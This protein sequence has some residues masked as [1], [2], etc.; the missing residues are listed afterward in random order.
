MQMA[1]I[2]WRLVSLLSCFLNIQ[3][4]KHPCTTTTTPAPVDLDP[5]ATTVTS[6]TTTSTSTTTTTI[7]DPDSNET[8]TEAPVADE[9]IVQTTTSTTTTM[10]PRWNLNESVVGKESYKCG[11]NL[12]P[13]LP[14][15]PECECA[16]GYE[17]LVRMD[18]QALRAHG[19]DPDAYNV[20]IRCAWGFEG[21]SGCLP[22]LPGRYKESPGNHICAGCDDGLYAGCS[23]LKCEQ[24]PKGMTAPVGA[25]GCSPCQKGRYGKPKSS[26][27]GE[28]CAACPKDTTSPAGSS[29]LE[30]CGCFPGFYGNPTDP[31]MP[32][33]LREC[34]PCPAGAVC[35]GG[36]W[37][38]FKPVAKLGYYDLSEA[39]SQ[40]IYIKKRYLGLEPADPYFVFGECRVPAAC[41]Q[42]FG[43][44]CAPGHNGT[45]CNMCQEG[46]FRPAQGEL[47]K[48]CPS[49]FWNIVF[50]G[51]ASILVGGSIFFLVFVILHTKGDAAK[52][53]HAIIFKI[54]FSYVVLT[55]SALTIT[56]MEMPSILM[57]HGGWVIT[58]MKEFQVQEILT[59]NLLSV[60][61]MYSQLPF[62][63]M[64]YAKTLMQKRLVVNL[65]ALPGLIVM[66]FVTEIVLCILQRILRKLKKCW[67]TCRGKGY[68]YVKP[69][70]RCGSLYKWSKPYLLVLFFFVHPML[71]NECLRG[72]FCVELHPDYPQSTFF[73]YDMDVPC[74]GSTIHVRF[75]SLAGLFFWSIFLPIRLY[76]L[77]KKNKDKLQDEDFKKHWGF[78]YNGY[79]PR[80]AYW[81]SV[82]FLRKLLIVASFV[83]PEL[84]ELERM[85]FLLMVGI[86][87]LW[88]HVY[89][90][91]Y[92]NRSYFLLDRLET[93]MLWA[94]VITLT[95]GLCLNPGIVGDS[96]K[97]N[98]EYQII[99]GI[100]MLVHLR[101]VQLLAYFVIRE[102]LGKMFCP[103]AVQSRKIKFDIHTREFD[104]SRLRSHERKFF[105]AIL[106]DSINIHLQQLNFFAFHY[107]ETAVKEGM[108]PLLTKKARKRRDKERRAE[109]LRQAREK[110][111]EEAA[112]QQNKQAA[113]QMLQPKKKQKCVALKK[114]CS[115][116][117][118]MI[119][120]ICRVPK[121]PCKGRKKKKKKAE[122][123]PM[124]VNPDDIVPDEPVFCDW[125]TDGID[126]ERLQLEMLKQVKAPVQMFHDETQKAEEEPKNPFLPNISTHQGTGLSEHTTHPEYRTSHAAQREKRA[127]QKDE[128]GEK[129]KE[130]SRKKKASKKN[131]FDDLFG[132]EEVVMEFNTDLP[133]VQDDE[134][135]E[136]GDDQVLMMWEAPDW[137]EKKEE[138][139]ELNVGQPRKRAET[140]H[141]RVKAAVERF[142]SRFMGAVPDAPDDMEGPE[143]VKAFAD[144]DEEPDAFWTAA[145]PGRFPEKEVEDK[146]KKKKK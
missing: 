77:L 132:A 64:G 89:F 109:A 66:I 130:T 38:E 105:V 131:Q 58:Y 96:N 98:L 117:K 137:L 39:L 50:I 125:W 44:P 29:E 127:V 91:P 142:H 120:L 33:S 134:D 126:V 20:K 15:R 35:P 32:E 7:F 90:E 107:I 18:F 141:D 135:E 56:Q 75:A 128:Q 51:G 42:T 9:C 79:E 111:L 67:G 37:P 113:E 27:Q 34:N 13:G 108:T 103:L 122:E 82:I 57:T 76:R 22:C 88:C 24:C 133:E 2:L 83:V 74:D 84:G 116:A 6:T 124:L 85:V 17:P 5:N 78:M 53:M 62:D 63:F 59:Q 146:S 10:A 3:A 60:D 28:Y 106:A 12:Q 23:A 94:F 55:S 49:F 92:D 110:M 71:V 54:F 31:T 1:R 47:C 136:G 40:E 48:E 97:Q 86:V 25:A 144:E 16:A 121:N 93:V 102:T 69:P 65:L 41:V 26:G 145:D 61:C 45:L 123:D 36:N 129:E 87:F 11:V 14:P 80:C 140:A 30:D 70:M 73:L 4:M 8:S 143:E 43:E 114:Y 95:G 100:V 115:M 99:R 101:F 138:E 104:L 112:A 21:V 68:T 19:F 119:K 52:P 81:E 46:W 139:D 118:T 72:L